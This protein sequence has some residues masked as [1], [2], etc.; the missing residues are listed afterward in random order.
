MEKLT[1]TTWAY[2][3]NLIH[4]EMFKLNVVT[5]IYNGLILKKLMTT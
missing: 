1:A 3:I 5:N 2:V 4:I